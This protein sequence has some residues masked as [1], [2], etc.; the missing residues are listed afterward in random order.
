MKSPLQRGLALRLSLLVLSAAGLVLAGIVLTTY[1]MAREALLH[2][3]EA[4]ARN[5]AQALVNR[6]ESVLTPIP[7]IVQG[8]VYD[9]EDK[10]L[11]EAAI[12]QRQRRMLRDNDALYGTAVAFEPEGWAKGRVH[13]APY[14]FRT[15]LGPK[16]THLGGPGYRYHAMDWYQIPRELDRIVWSEPYY[17]EGG[18]NSLMATCSVPFHQEVNGKRT[19]AGV[20]TADVSL[21]WLKR[22]VAGTSVLET[23][24][25]FLITN[26]GTY[27]THPAPGVAFNESIFSRAEEFNDPHLREIGKDMVKGG[28]RYVSWDSKH[29]GT[30]GFLVYAPVPSTGWSLGVFYPRDELLASVHS[31]ALVSAALGGGG[32]VALALLVVGI[33]RSI[34][35]PLRR[36]TT[37]AREV[38]GGN[39]DAP[40]PALHRDDEVRELAE[41]FGNMQVSLRDYIRDLTQATASRE[42]MESELRIAHD[43]QMGI[44]P[45]IFPPFPNRSEIDLFASLVPAREVGGDFYDFFPCGEDQFCFLIGDVSGKG[46]P[47]AFYMA[48]AKTLIKAVAESARSRAQRRSDEDQRA[49]ESAGGNAPALARRGADPGRIL[50]RASNDLAQ[51]NESC[52]FVT[53]F[54]AVL[55]MNTGELSYASAGHNPPVLM[56]AGKE[57]EYLPTCQ[58][59]VAGAMEGVEYTTE[60]LTL[61]PGDGL[62]LYTDGVTEAMNPAL[63]LYGEPRLLER[64]K[65]LGCR[66]PKT[67]CLRLGEDIHAFAAGAEQSDDITMLALSY[68]GR[69]ENA[70]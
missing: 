17:D 48:V 62:L 36:L 43:I 35:L 19:V 3:T 70:G 32:F 23:G 24:Y 4:T 42:R 26:N 57:P 58:E 6:I 65:A 39:L 52:M 29:T 9:M 55:N 67:L 46:V 54:C 14:T 30:R 64:A 51:D 59:P 49:N 21:E 37:A 38:A 1:F 13:F 20:V 10:H 15:P 12:F 31:L 68:L 8:V 40:L 33:A 5:K 66:D 50:T 60:T 53:I 63:E 45:K 44:L 28:S 41:S 27:V 69:G 2:H 18:G 56:R 22:L 11:D 16:A 7:S 47:A 61:A 34:T 25:A